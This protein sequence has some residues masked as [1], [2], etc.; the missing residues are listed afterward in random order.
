MIKRIAAFV[1]VLALAVTTV[2]NFNIAKAEEEHETEFMDFFQDMP[3]VE[4]LTKNCWGSG[5]GARDQGNGIE[6]R[7]NRTFCY[8]DGKILRDEDTG[9][10][11]LF[12]SRWNESGGHWDWFNSNAFGST[13]DDLFGPYT[14]QGLLWPDNQGGKGHNV[15]PLMLQ[16][17]DWD[18]YG[19]YAIVVSETR[20]GD[21]FVSNSLNGP[22]RHVG[23]LA[24][25]GGWWHSNTCV[26][27]SPDGGYH[28]IQRN[29]EIAVSE[30][31]LGPYTR[32]ND[33]LWTRVRGMP[34]G[35]IE[36]AVVWFNDGLFHCT[37]NKWDSR[38]AYYL[39]SENGVDDWQLAPGAAYMPDEDFLRYEDGTVNHWTKI[40]RPNVYIEDDVV[41]AMTFAVID[42]QKDDDHGNDSHGSKVIVVPFDGEGQAEFAHEVW[43]KY[44]SIINSKKPL[45]DATAMFWSN[46][47]SKNT[48]NDNILQTQKFTAEDKGL[49][50]EEIR[51]GDNSNWED[52]IAYLKFDISDYDP[53]ET[54]KVVLSLIF[55]NKYAGNHNT[56]KIVVSL[57]DND[58]N[59]GSMTWD[60]KPE[61]KYDPDDEENTT[62]TSK[63]IRTNT[64]TSDIGWDTQDIEVDVTNLV[65]QV[66][67]SDDTITL[68][69]CATEGN[70]R[71]AFYSKES[72]VH[73]P[74][75]N[76]Y[77][78]TPSPT[79]EPTEEPQPT[80]DQPSVQPT[81]DQQTQV[82]NNIPT[83]T[84]VVQTPATVTSP[85]KTTLKVK[86]A[87]SGKVTFTWK[88]VNG[89]NG[90]QIQYS[91]K[92]S[93]KYKTLATVKNGNKIKLTKSM[94]RGRK[95][96]FKIRAYKIADGKKVYGKLSAAKSVKVK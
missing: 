80:N 72:G 94:K 21:C 68:A 19:K 79:P 10:Y 54:G 11:H 5:V 93:G 73:T 35:N 78:P 15:W 76:Y 45:A 86:S 92:K 24:V 25:N 63:S 60:N 27:A 74:Q 77:P 95:F 47:H 37:V 64:T 91:T 50:G 39:V 52:K 38:R 84:Q 56:N 28:I 87:K 70:D 22:W 83:Q 59:E 41:K 17:K 89:A 48:G 4:E 23:T 14:D 46:D 16:E 29:G 36:D 12:G 62:A 6:S 31:L 7:N 61:L 57:A 34:T 20:S 43:D 55:S 1:S 33:G 85:A 58:W 2:F 82:A 53:E 42:V 13:S 18:T 32:V 40:E 30:N 88:K 67:E 8:W 9:E 90:Y 3:I 75:L 66:Y 96:F 71:L 26:I 65:N 51:N 44:N 81:N 49:F 69:V